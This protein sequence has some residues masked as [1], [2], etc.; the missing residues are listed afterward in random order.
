MGHG[1][2]Q[3]GRA[4]GEEGHLFLGLWGQKVLGDARGDKK[5][6]GVSF[7][8]AVPSV[9]IALICGKADGKDSGKDLF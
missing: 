7:A 8:S 2:A 9:M 6:S 1:D 5:G 4:G 3:R